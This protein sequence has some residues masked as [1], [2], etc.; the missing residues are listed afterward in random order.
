MTKLGLCGDGDWR[1]DDDGPS[2]HWL[3]LSRIVSEMNAD[4]NALVFHYVRA[5]L[6]ECRGNVSEAARR[7]RIH[8][9]SLQR[10]LSKKSP[11]ETLR[12]VAAR[13]KKEALATSNGPACVNTADPSNQ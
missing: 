8:R 3:E 10:L 7:M 4:P 11:N 12:Q 5:T 13:R 1:K 9:K 6:A 2:L